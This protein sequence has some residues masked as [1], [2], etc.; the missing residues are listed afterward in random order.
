M[1]NVDTCAG[2]SS[3]LGGSGLTDLDGDGCF[4]EEDPDVDGDGVLNEADGC[5]LGLLGWTSS[6]TLDHD[7]DGCHDVE[8]DLDDDQDGVFD[9]NDACNRSTPP[10]FAEAG[11]DDHDGDGCHDDEDDDND[12]DGRLN[13]ADACPTVSS[14]GRAT[15]RW[16]TSIRTGATTARKTPTTTTTV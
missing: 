4:D 14:V 10:R 16:T 5:D 1:D 7:G 3:L 12:N 2:P 15:A 13:D 8:E 11:F 6:A 9:L